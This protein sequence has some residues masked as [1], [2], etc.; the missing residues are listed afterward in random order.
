MFQIKTDNR[1]AVEA[2]L[3]LQV[4][5]ALEAVGLHAQEDVAQRAP[6]KTS[7]LKNSITHRTAAKH[8]DIGTNVEY[9]PYQEF[10]T[11]KIPA[12]HFM[13]NGIESNMNKY[14]EII[15]SILSKG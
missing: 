10:G 2:A 9:A 15:E 6:V 12:K 13:K 3:A 1:K 8:V 5:V 11:S 7:R 14:V 4:R